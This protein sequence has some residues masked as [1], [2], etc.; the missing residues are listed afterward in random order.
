M[1]LPYEGVG[2]ESSPS[3]RTLPWPSSGNG[4]VFEEYHIEAQKIHASSYILPASI[5]DGGTMA[6]GTEEGPGGG[7]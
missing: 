1:L 7:L 5:H 2:S 4:G 3:S 6:S